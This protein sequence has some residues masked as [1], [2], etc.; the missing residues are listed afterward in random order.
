M[1]SEPFLSKQFSVVEGVHSHCCVTTTI[2]L[3]NSFHLAQ[4]KL[5]TH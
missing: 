3:Q 1:P 5:H 2:R 4:L